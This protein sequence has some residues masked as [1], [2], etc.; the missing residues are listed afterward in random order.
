MVARREGGSFPGAGETGAAHYSLEGGRHPTTDRI[1]ERGV[2]QV[3][4]LIEA[5]VRML[6][7]EER[8]AAERGR[9]KQL[10]E[11]KRREQTNARPDQHI[12]P[13]RTSIEK[14]APRVCDGIS[15]F[16]D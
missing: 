15:G 1:Q 5:L 11:E 7:R 8:I 6:N 9:R 3:D 12:Q 2:N 16:N 14:T 10:R 4:A 13:A